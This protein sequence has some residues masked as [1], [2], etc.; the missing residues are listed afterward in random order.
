MK[1]VFIVP[2]FHCDVV[3]RRPPAEQTRIRAHQYASA[4]ETLRREPAFRFEFDQARLVRE[5]LDAHPRWLEPMRRLVREGRLE[6]TGGGETIP[7]TNMP[8]GE[9]LIR[10]LLLGRIWFEE[11]LGAAPIV[12]N[13]D[14]AFGMSGQLPQIFRQF[15]Y[16]WFRNSRMPGLD[17][18]ATRRGLI[19]QGLDGSRIF[20]GPVHGNV[21]LVTH[22]CNL[23]VIYRPAEFAR[24]SLEQAFAGDRPVTYWQYCS[25]E[26]L[27][28]GD[29]VRMILAR[30]RRRGADARFGLAREAL[31]AMERRG[32]RV[33]VVAGEFNPCLTGCY[34]TRIGVKQGYRAA[35][36]GT[37]AAEAAAA[38]AAL[39]G[40]AYPRARL[41]AAWRSL[42][43]I[44]F[45]DALCGCHTRE[46]NRAVLR[47]CGQTVR[48]AGGMAAAAVR[49][50]SP[51]RGRRPGVVLFNPLPWPR[52]EAVPL[53][54]P[55]GF[56]PA[57]PDGTRLPAERHGAVTCA[58]VDLPPMGCLR[59]PLRRGSA[60]RPR[61]RA[62]AAGRSFEVGPHRIVPRDDGLRIERRDWNRVLADGPFPEVRFRN[63]DGTQIG[64]AHV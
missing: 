64:R 33:P 36:Q 38:C 34:V 12:A 31:A 13:M 47:A 18:E 61:S 8:C 57:A 62:R 52:R 56:V 51:R 58:V 9:G 3:W 2:Q 39:D 48:A 20:S 55:A 41:L 44:Q 59:L 35:E 17:Q 7:D 28:D 26:D 49:A 30:V 11:T 15:G 19:W 6:I 29:I 22:V 40:A 50:L 37:L 14:D 23:P 1:Q 46:V 53:D 10:N 21:E 25:E 54:V 24:H 16:R 60:P 42:A 63:E 27:V 45:H 32:G 4:L 43:F 5:F